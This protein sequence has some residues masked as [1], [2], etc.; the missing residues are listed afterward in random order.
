MNSTPA[1]DHKFLKLV[2]E[3]RDRILR[4][5]RVYAWNSP[6]QDDLYQEILLQ[7]WRGLPGLKEDQFANTW[8]Y[9]VAINTAMSFVASGHHA[10]AASFNS[11]TRT[12]GTRLKRGRQRKTTRTIALPIFTPRSTNWAH[13][14]KRWSPYS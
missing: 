11:N 7:V 13:S 14:K 2:S 1:D 4:V 12:S 8:L 5:C 10:W 6:D 3:N 9:R